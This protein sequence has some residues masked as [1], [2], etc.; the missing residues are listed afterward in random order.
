MYSTWQPF[1]QVLL[2]DSP[3]LSYIDIWYANFLPLRFTVGEARDL[4]RRYT[5]SDELAPLWDESAERVSQ[6]LREIAHAPV[7]PKAPVQEA[8]QVVA[9]STNS[10]ETKSDYNEDMVTRKTMAIDRFVPGARQIAQQ[11]PPQGRGQTPL[12]PPPLPPP[13]G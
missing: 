4:G 5:G 9:E 6:R 1:G 10:S 13:S 2:V 7:E 3:L 11:Q 12:A 8:K